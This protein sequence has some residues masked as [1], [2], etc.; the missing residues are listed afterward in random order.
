MK[1]K[2]RPSRITDR[3]VVFAALLFLTAVSAFGQTPVGTAFSYQASV[4]VTGS[5]LN[6]SADFEFSLWDADEFGNMIGSVIAVNDVAVVYG[7]FTLELDFGLDAFDVDARWLEVHVRSP[8]DPS[9]TAPFTTLSPRQALTPSPFALQTI[10]VR[11]HSA[12]NP[13][14]P[15]S[16]NI[17]ASYRGNSV[18]AGVSGATI[19][20]GGYSGS[21]N[22]VEGDFGTIGGGHGNVASGGGTV[23]G[24]WENVADSGGA[25]VGGGWDNVATYPYG[26]IGG[27]VHNDATACS[28]CTIAG[29]GK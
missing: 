10:G 27:G 11:T 3:S 13:T 15:D 19:A 23:G 12:N 5:P 7:L 20:G 14:Y 26:T 25:V 8:H 29:G 22:T 6:D 1:S 17:V 4:T 18:M 28:R 2:I 24:G 9:G 21:E 16:P